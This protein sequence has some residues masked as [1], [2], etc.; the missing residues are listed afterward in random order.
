MTSSTGFN[1]SWVSDI[2]ATKRESNVVRQG[3]GTIFSFRQASGGVISSS[4]L[5]A[6]SK[7]VAQNL[8]DIRSDWRS[9]IRP[10][11]NSLPAGDTDQRWSTAIGKGLPAKIDCFVYG[12]Q[13]STLFVF[14]DADATKAD[15]RYWLTTDLRPKTIA[16]AFEDVYESINNVST[17]LTASSVV[18]LGPLWAAIGESYRD[19][20]QVAQVGSL[21][22]RVG[23][24][25]TYVSQLNT[26]IYEPTTYSYQIGTPLPYSIASM[27]DALLKEHTVTGGWGSNPSGVSHAD[28]P[29]AAHDHPFTEVKPPPPNSSTQARVGPYTSLYNEVLR[30]RYE[31]QATRGSVN[32]YSDVTSPI[33]GSPVASLSVH[34]NYTG[35]GTAAT[36]NPHGI[37]YTN[38]GANLVFNA[39][40]SFTGMSDNTDSSPT[41]ASTNY[42]T[43]SGSLEQA[44]GELDAAILT[45]IGTTVI[46]KDY[47]YDRSGMSETDRANTPIAIDHNLG[48]KP[49]VNVLDLSPTFGDYYGQYS[50]PAIELNIVHMSSNSFEIWTEAAVI[51]VIVIG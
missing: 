16:E 24:L 39:I 19:S 26:D 30:L 46:R 5:S 12:V 47:S 11:L 25:E 14:N 2:T 22:T 15:G 44:V 4:E 27:L 6:F 38:T 21:D 37:N 34:I 48:K 32:W 7:S 43:Q 42:V 3:G 28:I 8:Q 13:G 23:T 31:I 18:D 10:V 40:R 36:S 50:S 49:I 29:A 41:Y 51:E 9:Y 17:A 45:A 1:W 35:S 20:G 33:I